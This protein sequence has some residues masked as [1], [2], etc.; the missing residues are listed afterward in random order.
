[1]A[2]LAAA[3][4]VATACQEVTVPSLNNPIIESLTENPDI[5][6]INVSTVG[7]LIT[8]RDR[9]GTEASAMG[10]LGKESYNLDQAEP[11]NVISYLQGP[12]EPGGFVQDLGWTAGYRNVVQGQAI[13]EAVDKI[14]ETATPTTVSYTLAQKQGIR[15]F[16]K[17]IVAM[18]LLTQVR[19]RDQV[20]IVVD[21]STDRTAPLGAI[22]TKA[23]GL[24]RIVTLLDEART[25]L[26][27]AGTTFAF[28]LPTGFLNYSLPAVANTPSN[29]LLL[30]RAIKARAE[31]Y[32]QQWGSALTAIGESFVEATT[33]T[34][35]NLARGGYHVYSTNSGDI[36]NPLFDQT[37]T[38]FYV[39][40]S[41]LSGAQSRPVAPVP[42]ATTPPPDL[43]LS[44][45]TAV[46]TSRTT[47]TVQGTHKFMNYPTNVSPVPII[48]NE[49][50]ILLRA[51]ARYNSGDSPGALADINFIR[52]NSGGLAP[53][54][55]FADANAFVDELLYNRTYS[56]L[57]EGGHR[58]VDYRRY[59]R[60]AQ[61]PKINTQLNE[62]TFPYVMLPADECTQR[63][64]QPAV[65]CTQ[66]AG[67]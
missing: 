60:L 48:K 55:G 2:T 12:I 27:A 45:K 56:L 19:I 6:T 50:L 41:I 29:F 34:P 58:W 35:A 53:L 37:P 42:P 28:P 13:L 31:V 25:H 14:P 44:S 26:Q 46:G 23:E 52:V 32:R 24:T 59:N 51:E 16:V 9:V 15:G 63:G 33:A 3:A 22:V 8:L 67:Q 36:I 38:R 1:M 64:N 43:R 62:R 11:R 40:P 17:T 61:L 39:H 30:N 7:M 65:A 5:S 49:E 18:E 21:V 4:C 66:V 54:A 20:G 57:F 47:V 10:I